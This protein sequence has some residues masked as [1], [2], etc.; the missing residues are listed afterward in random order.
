MGTVSSIRV[1]GKQYFGNGEGRD[2]MGVSM[3]QRARILHRHSVNHINYRFA[4]LPSGP[5]GQ[6]PSPKAKLTGGPDVLIR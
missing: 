2:G 3:V 1:L 5:S 6:T 4:L